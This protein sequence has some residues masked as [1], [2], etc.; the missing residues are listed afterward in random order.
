[1]SVP[2]VGAIVGGVL[3]QEAIKGLVLVF[4]NIEQLLAYSYLQLTRKMLGQ[5]GLRKINYLSTQSNTIEID[6]DVL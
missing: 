6:A 4:G 1:M 5:F 2:P 3:G